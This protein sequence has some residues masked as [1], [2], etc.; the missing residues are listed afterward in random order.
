MRQLARNNDRQWFQ[1]RKEIYQTHVYEPMR[2]LV[3][4]INRDLRKFAADHVT[5]PKKSIYRIYRDTRFSKDKTPYK[6]HIAAIFP[7]K[8]MA[9]HAGAGFYFQFSPEG[10]EIAGGVYMP[11]P[12]EMLAVRQA[13]GKQ[14]GQWRKLV[15]D[16]RL[17]ATV[18]P[19]FGE[20]L[21]RVPK[22]FDADHP[23]ADYLKMKQWYF[24][25]TLKAEEALQPSIHPLIIWYFKGMAPVMNWMNNAIL[26]TRMDEDDETSEIPKRPEPMF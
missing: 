15:E 18:G 16:K 23:A 8:G 3:E 1:P 11:G 24:D 9:K 17:V 21:A 4:L 26:Q 19:L 12:E 6:T 22:G 10:L 14:P 5:E 13:I 25:V 20:K 2:L 7:R